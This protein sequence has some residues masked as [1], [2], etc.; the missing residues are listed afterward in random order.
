MHGGRGIGVT[1][2]N[3][4]VFV[5]FKRIFALAGAMLSVGAIALAGPSPLS[6]VAVRYVVSE[7]LPE[8]VEITVTDPLERALFALPRVCKINSTTGYGSVNVEIR[9]E[10]GATEQDLATVGRRID[11]LVLAS[12]VVVKS[13]SVTLTSPRL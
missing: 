11:E 1:V 2:N 7:Q 10:G 12:E 3:L 5:T 4:E 6:I 13:R 9:F 8:R